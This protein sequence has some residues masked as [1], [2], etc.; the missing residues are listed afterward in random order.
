MG[1]RDANGRALDR[2]RLVNRTVDFQRPAVN[3]S[4][5]DACGPNTITRFADR[6]RAGSQVTAGHH[7]GVGVVL[8][9]DVG[10][11]V[12]PVVG[13]GLGQRVN[14]SANCVTGS[15]GFQAGPPPLGFCT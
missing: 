6:M 3:Q 11:D 10:F 7:G 2:M 12:L 4:Q 9:A 13:H 8:D 15:A 5:G 14:L 1:E